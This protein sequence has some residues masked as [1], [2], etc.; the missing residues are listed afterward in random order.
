MKTL[1]IELP[2]TWGDKFCCWGDAEMVRLKRNVCAS[3]WQTA[4]RLAD[5]GTTQIGLREFVV[6]ATMSVVPIEQKE[7]KGDE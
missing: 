2:A 6:L 3:I 4:Q 1:T 5:K 7:V